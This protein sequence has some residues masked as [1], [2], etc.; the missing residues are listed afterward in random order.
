[1]NSSNDKIDRLELNNTGE[2]IESIMR[3]VFK[4]SSIKV[5]KAIATG[6]MDIMLKASQSG[7]NAIA[8]NSICDPQYSSYYG[9]TKEEVLLLLR[10]LFES[11]DDY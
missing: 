11:E 10:Q 1:M 4:D 2:L 7:V 8:I 6:V 3:C 9:F 5:K